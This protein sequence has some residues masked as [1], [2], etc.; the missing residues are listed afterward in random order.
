MSITIGLVDFSNNMPSDPGGYLE[1][2]L[3]LQQLTT[4]TDDPCG[5]GS[6]MNGRNSLPKFMII[7]VTYRHKILESPGIIFRLFP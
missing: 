3:T 7:C 2:R 1:A 5:D 6:N 4:R